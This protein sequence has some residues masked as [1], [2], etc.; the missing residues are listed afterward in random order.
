MYV[1]FFFFFFFFLCVFLCVLCVF[2]CVL[3]MFIVV[4]V[5]CH[6]VKLWYF[7]KTRDLMGGWNVTF[8][9]D[10]S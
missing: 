9:Y 5:L 2:L 3:C 4:D 7:W 1:V 8:G 6:E 10:L